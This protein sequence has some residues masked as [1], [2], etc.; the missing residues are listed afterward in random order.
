MRARNSKRK[1]MSKNKHI[2]SSKPRRI[3]S[4]ATPKDIDPLEKPVLVKQAKSDPASAE[5]VEEDMAELAHNSFAISL[6]YRNASRAD[7]MQEK[8]RYLAHAR[9]NMNR[10]TVRFASTSVFH[11]ANYVRSVRCE[12]ITAYHNYETEADVFVYGNGKVWW[13]GTMTQVN[14]RYYIDRESAEKVAREMIDQ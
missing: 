11:Y 5:Q 3:L 2:T 13:V 1:A 7:K 10:G 4:T 9:K 14:D 6:G 12:A 8:R